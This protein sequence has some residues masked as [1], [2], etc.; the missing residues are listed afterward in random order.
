ML[1]SLSTTTLPWH[2]PITDFPSEP[3]PQPGTVSNV[4]RPH[5]IRTG[6]ALSAARAG[7]ESARRRV[8][9]TELERYFTNRTPRLLGW[10]DR[11]EFLVPPACL[12]VVPANQTGV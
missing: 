11:D 2:G 4:I 6:W 8:R 5:P 1:P 12:A 9:A 3:R 7:S 10:R